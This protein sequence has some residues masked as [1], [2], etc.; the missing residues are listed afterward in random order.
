MNLR[1]MLELTDFSQDVGLNQLLID[2]DA[3]YIPCNLGETWNPTNLDILLNEI[4][5]AHDGMLIHDGKNGVVYIPEQS[6]QRDEYESNPTPNQL[7]KFHV[8]N[9]STLQDM[10]RKDEFKKYKFETRRDGKFC[11]S[12]PGHPDQ[13]VECELHVCK[14]C[15]TELNY[16][17]FVDRRSEQNKIRDSFNLEEFYRESGVYTLDWPQVSRR[18]RAL[19]G[20]KCE[21]CGDFLGHEKMRQFLHV[22]HK[23]RQKDDNT[24]E[25]LQV[26]CIRCHADQD[27]HDRLKVSQDYAEYRKIKENVN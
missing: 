26:L 19:A 9:C 24:E 13:I 22:H 12:F 2:M 1:E 21:L 15:L 4:E 17:N 20:W 18:C 10:K 25:N 5:P 16:K 23:N 7:K 8:A 3:K 14:N 6:I 11:V 27:Y